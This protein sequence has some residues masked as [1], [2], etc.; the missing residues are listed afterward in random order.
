MSDRFVRFS[1]PLDKPLKEL[2]RKI[3]S[4]NVDW[5]SLSLRPVCSPEIEVEVDLEDKEATLYVPKCLLDE[6]SPIYIMIESWITSYR[7][8]HFP[9]DKWEKMIVDFFEKS[10]GN[11]FKSKI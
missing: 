1:F 9:P 10:K 5:V 2:E 8:K 11:L 6:R 3:E 7:L 4:Y